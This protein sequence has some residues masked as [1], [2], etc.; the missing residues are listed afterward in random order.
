MKALTTVGLN[1]TKG[2][3]A[4]GSAAS[5][6]TDISSWYSVAPDVL[7]MPVPEKLKL[8]KGVDYGD[9]VALESVKKDNIREFDA[10]ARQAMNYAADSSDTFDMIRPTQI[11]NMLWGKAFDTYAVLKNGKR[12]K[13]DQNVKPDAYKS[14]KQAIDSTQTHK[15]TDQGVRKPKHLYEFLYSFRGIE[16]ASDFKSKKALEASRLNIP[17]PDIFSMAGFSGLGA[18]GYSKLI[19]SYRDYYTEKGVSQVTGIIDTQ[20]RQRIEILQSLAHY[21]SIN[22][23][24]TVLAIQEEVS[25]YMIKISKSKDPEEIANLREKIANKIDYAQQLIS[26]DISDVVTSMLLMR[27]AEDLVKKVKDDPKKKEQVL[28]AINDIAT[29]ADSF[30]KAYTTVSSESANN[31]GKNKGEAIDGLQADIA[32]FRNNVLQSEWQ[33]KLF[34][35]YML[36]TF[37]VQRS[38]DIAKQEMMYKNRDMLSPEEEAY[39]GKLTASVYANNLNSFGAFIKATGFDNV[40][41]FY[42]A[43]SDIA[44]KLL[45][46]KSLN[47]NTFMWM[48]QKV[49]GDSTDVSKVD[50]SNIDDLL[51]IGKDDSLSSVTPDRALS[52]STDKNDIA[53]DEQTI[54][55]LNQIGKEKDQDLYRDCL[56]K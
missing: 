2:K 50:I 51:R 46:P 56:D 38:A 39:F 36:G 26:Q 25:G 35:T 15:Y 41:D 21:K 12:V 42:K 6:R 34:D 52:S 55:E 16:K 3:L 5:A 29:K 28:R 44:Q 7:R 45:D 32:N 49:G 31:Q 23:D 19:K 10:S 47:K 30:K 54:M 14:Y 11:S 22:S 37:N 48:Y 4:V 53:M 43:Y 40:R 24:K 9:V 1:A 8:P 27:Q 13:I 20:R 33:R 17:D 18:K